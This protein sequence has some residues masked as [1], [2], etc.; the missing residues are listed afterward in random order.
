MWLSLGP[1]LRGRVHILD[2]AA[3]FA[4]ARRFTAAFAPGQPLSARVT[5]VDAE[6]HTLDLSVRAA[7]GGAA[8]A[9]ARPAKAAGGKRKAAAAA[10]GGGGVLEAGAVVMG[11][12]QAV[13]GA[14]LVVQ[15]GPRAQ[16]RVA[17]TDIHDAW[18]PNALTG[19]EEGAFVRARVLEGAA[20][21]AGRVPLSLR[22]SQG[23]AVDGLAPPAAAAAEGGG[24]KR[25][26]GAA[27][28]AAAVPAAAA[29]AAPEVLPESA[30]S[31]GGAARGYV[32]AAGRAGLFV[33]LDRGHEVRCCCAALSAFAARLPVCVVPSEHNIIQPPTPPPPP[34]PRP[35]LPAGARAPVQPIRRLH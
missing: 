8:E 31:E 2:A 24:A 28:A 16:G 6:R 3:D 12:V 26:K 35:A 25:R 27:A 1:T 9:A 4:E 29:E 14:G 30:F 32:K 19:L 11:R 18:Q 10:A 20:D 33:V 7:V 5:A 22:P 17:L 23:G 15:L 13:R 21:A 34:H